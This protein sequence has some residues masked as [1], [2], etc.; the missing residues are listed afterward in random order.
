MSAASSLPIA[1]QG[2]VEGAV[3]VI[4]LL[5]GLALVAWHFGPTLLRTAGFC[6]LWVA[7]AWGSQDGLG[8]CATFL[9]LGALAWPGGTLWYAKRRARWPSVLSGRILSCVLGPRG[10]IPAPE[11]PSVPIGSSRHQ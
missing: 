8:Y 1:S 3:S 4:G 6:S 9:V 2:F 5:A 7:W 10:P 11:R